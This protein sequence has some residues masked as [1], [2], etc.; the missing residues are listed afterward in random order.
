MAWFFLVSNLIPPNVYLEE[1]GRANKLQAGSGLKGS[2]RVP[3]SSGTGPPDRFGR[4]D[5][6]G[7][8][9]EYLFK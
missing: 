1:L 6:W 8:S 3:I 5:R 4:L 7:I 2:R 9:V